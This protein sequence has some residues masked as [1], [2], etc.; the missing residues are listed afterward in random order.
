[1]KFVLRI[2]SLIFIVL[3]IAGM[4][5]ILQN[6]QPLTFRDFLV[7]IQNSPQIDMSLFDDFINYEI[8]ADS[9]GVF[10]FLARFLNVFLDILKF[11]LYICVMLTQVLLY[12]LHYIQYIS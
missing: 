5:L 10:A 8:I 6:Q 2:L 12:V 1:M 3:F 9:W 11:V 7:A 4:F